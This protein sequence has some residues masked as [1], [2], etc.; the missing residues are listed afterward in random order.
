MCTI[1]VN[2]AILSC[3]ISYT[4]L[5]ISNFLFD[6][7]TMSSPFD[8]FLFGQVSPY[9]CTSDDNDPATATLAG[10]KIEIYR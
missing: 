1:V 9:S 6:S 7:F 5:M 8:I 3:K 10:S 2:Y 4:G